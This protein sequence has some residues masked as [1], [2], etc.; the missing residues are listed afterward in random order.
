MGDS[1]M[2]DGV[3]LIFG[4]VKDF[5]PVVKELK[6]FDKSGNAMIDEADDLNDKIMNINELSK[7]DPQLKFVTDT[8]FNQGIPMVPFPDVARCL[9]LTAKDSTMKIKEGYAILGFDYSVKASNENC[10]FN[11]KS[12]LTQKEARMAQKLGSIGGLDFGAV[13]EKMLK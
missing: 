13:G 4:M 9:G 3:P 12:S 11:I 2:A 6:V 8:V 1:N 7:T 5:R 10:I